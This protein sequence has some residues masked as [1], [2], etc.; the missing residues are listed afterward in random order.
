MGTG[1]SQGPHQLASSQ[2]LTKFL[3]GVGHRR[4]AGTSPACLGWQ[5]A[6]PAS[7]L[8]APCSLSCLLWRRQQEAE[9]EGGRSRGRHHFKSLLIVPRCSLRSGHLPQA[10]QILS[11]EGTPGSAAWEDESP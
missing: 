9:E 5:Q 3:G 2:V 7:S 1:A 10:L 8:P 6:L 4:V 11:G